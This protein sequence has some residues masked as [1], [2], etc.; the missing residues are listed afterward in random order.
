MVDQLLKLNLTVL[1]TYKFF[2]EH[3][4]L[5]LLYKVISV[6]K[7]NWL[8]LNHKALNTQDSRE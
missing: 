6:D 1:I 4:I 7:K 2:G 8:P 5:H 3:S